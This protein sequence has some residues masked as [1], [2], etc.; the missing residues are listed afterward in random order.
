M[1][2]TGSKTNIRM[3]D[4]SSF[5]TIKEITRV[6]GI[7]CQELGGRDQYIH[8]LLSH[9]NSGRWYYSHLEERK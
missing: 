3:R 7:L 5:L 9:G 1:S 6:L 8:F 2:G 4:V